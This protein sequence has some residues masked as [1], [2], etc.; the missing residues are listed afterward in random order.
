MG[1]RPAAGLNLLPV[2]ESLLAPGARILSRT[3]AGLSPGGSKWRGVQHR[4]CGS[5][6]AP[7]EAGARRARSAS[8]EGASHIN[9]RV[10][11]GSPREVESPFQAEWPRWVH[12]PSRDRPPSA[13]LRTALPPLTQRWHLDSR[14]STEHEPGGHA[15]KFNR[16]EA[17]TPKR[18][19]RRHGPSCKL[20][21]PLPTRQWHTHAGPPRS[22]LVPKRAPGGALALGGMGILHVP[23]IPA[24]RESMRIKQSSDR[25]EAGPR[26]VRVSV[27]RRTRFGPPARP[28]DRECRHWVRAA[29][30]V[31][32]SASPV[33]ATVP[34]PDSARSRRR[35]AHRAHARTGH[36]DSLDAG[37][38]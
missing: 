30:S 11:R 36:P 32:P 21:K 24:L 12:R 27:P 9:F 17:G 20:R 22:A 35:G 33:D 5:V 34:T 16:S 8:P 7:G 19:I 26:S 28:S 2:R 23:L 18:R 37:S 31:S 13:A 4:G 38:P 25:P 29:L 14:T 15:P 10:D 3:W 1:D 6:S